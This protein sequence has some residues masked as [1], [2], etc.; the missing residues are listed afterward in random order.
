MDEKRKKSRES[1][2][3]MTHPTI[4]GSIAILPPIAMSPT[5]EAKKT[6]ANPHLGARGKLGR[7]HTTRRAESGKKVMTARKAMLKMDER[8]A[9]LKLDVAQRIRV[10]QRIV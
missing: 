10:R 1:L 5:A 2:F 8:V 4:V 9:R 3:S 7:F 6:S